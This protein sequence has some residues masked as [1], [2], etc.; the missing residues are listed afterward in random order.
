MDNIVHCNADQ[1]EREGYATDLN[2]SNFENDLDTAI[3][4]TSIEEDHINS[5]YIYSNID[6]QRQNSTL[7]LLSAIANIQAIVSTTDQPTST[8]ILYCSSGQLV[9]L[10][11]WEDPHYFTFAFPNL[12]PFG[13]G[14]HLEQRKGP[15]SLEAWAMWT[16]QHHSHR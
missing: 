11:D 9:L 7:R 2:D 16:L 1:H 15:I 8:T 3:A 12:F 5:N 14:D 6:D 13:T 10:N 4:G